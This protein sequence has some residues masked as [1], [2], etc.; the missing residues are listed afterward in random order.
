MTI[1]VT[2]TELIATYCGAMCN[3]NVTSLINDF[4]Y[5]TNAIQRNPDKLS[6]IGAS[7]FA[8]SFSKC[9]SATYLEPLS[10]YAITVSPS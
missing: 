4:I 7:T 5:I 2:C 1:A 8:T 9:L 6:I 3:E 10:M